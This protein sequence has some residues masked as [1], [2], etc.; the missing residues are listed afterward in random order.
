[1]EDKWYKLDNAAK[2][3]P[4]IREANWAP[5]F[6]VDAVLREEVDYGC[7]QSALLLTYKRFPTFSVHIAKGLF[8][9][10]FEPRESEPAVTLENTYPLRPFSKEKDNGYLFRVL[11]FKKRVSFEVFHSITDGYGAMVFLKTLLYNYF[12]IINGRE[13]VDDLLQLDKYGILYY[14]DLPTSYEMEDSFHHFALNNVGVKLGE[15]PAFKIPGTRIRRGTVRVTHVLLG[16]DALHNLSKSYDSTITEFLTGLLVYSILKA[17]VYDSFNKRPVKVS[18]P[19]NLRKHFPSRT[20]R[21]FSSYINVEVFPEKGTVDFD[22]KEICGIV[23]RQ[24]REGLDHDL[25]RSRFSSNVNAERNIAMRVSPLFL[26]NAVLKSTYLLYG[27]RL[28]TTTMSNIG[29][30]EL[31]EEMA[32]LVERF[33]FVN[34][35]PRRDV[36]NCSA[37]S[38][39]DMI[40]ISFTSNMV[41]N[42]I[43]REF[44]GFLTDRGI[45]IKV[46]ANY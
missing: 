15:S 35:A 4:A 42:S 40:S 14:K 13:L 38:F 8:W 10:Y 3:Y 2:I 11:Y 45:E 9:Y 21:N 28:A 18:V 7:L 33:D 27:E 17:R 39:N 23:R 43:I 16:V 5:I 46:E 22:V 44:A 36:I 34:S 29:C 37:I 12:M 26:K 32:H 25:L 31:P 30:I 1:M 19:V 41:E 20:M 24:I 6:R